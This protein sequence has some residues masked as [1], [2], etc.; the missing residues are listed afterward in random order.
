MSSGQGGIGFKP[1]MDNLLMKKNRIR[2]LKFKFSF[3]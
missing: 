3:K 1:S 2:N